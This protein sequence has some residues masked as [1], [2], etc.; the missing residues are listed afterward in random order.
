VV[1]TNPSEKYMSSSVGENLFPTKM[2]K[3][4]IPYMKW[5]VI[6]TSHVPVTTNQLGF[7]NKNM[8]FNIQP[9]A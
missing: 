1:S 4:D 2:W 8:G 9:A 5:K 7:H 3:D 6:S